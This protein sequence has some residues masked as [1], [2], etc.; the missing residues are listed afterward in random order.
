MDRR[1]PSSREIG[2]PPLKT[3]LYEISIS[4][5]NTLFGVTQCGISYLGQLS[6]SHITNLPNSYNTWNIIRTLAGYPV[7]TGL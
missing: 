6:V 4:F 3:K 5:K 1:D 7:L 2:A